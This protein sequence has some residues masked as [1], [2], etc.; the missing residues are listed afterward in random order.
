[1]N[2]VPWQCLINE[3][4][5]TGNQQEV[6][7]LNGQLDA[8]GRETEKFQHLLRVKED[9]LNRAVT[10]SN[11]QPEL[12]AT[13]ATENLRLKDELSEMVEKNRLLEVDKVGLSQDNARFSSRLGEL[14]TTFS[15]LRGELDSVKSDATSMAERH[16]QLES[17][18][19]RY[20]ERMR[21][22]E[23]KA[24]NRARICDEL[25]TELEE[26]V[27]AN[28]LLKAELEST[29]QIQKVLEE[30]RD[31]LMAKLAQAEADLAEALRSVEAAEAHTT[32]SGFPV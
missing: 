23:E 25:K 20:K 24:E 30:D 29:T 21:V 6:D 11:L 1:M 19:A 32:I 16:R 8:Q 15:Q 7:D 12:D 3:G 4:M 28:D 5:H 2:G 31:E 27:D 18:S 26:T 17:E 10:L 13:K 9:E 22:F 14:E